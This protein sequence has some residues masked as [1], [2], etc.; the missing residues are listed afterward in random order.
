MR[1]F[2]FYPQASDVGKTR[3][4]A[5]TTIHGELLEAVYEEDA[6]TEVPTEVLASS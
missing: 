6:L 5:P 3:R 2:S 1:M 4:F